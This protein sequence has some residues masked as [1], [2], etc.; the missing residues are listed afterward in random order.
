MI[1]GGSNNAKYGNLVLGFNLSNVLFLGNQ[2]RGHILQTCMFKISLQAIMATLEVIN[3]KVRGVCRQYILQ[4][5]CEYPPGKCGFR[6]PQPITKRDMLEAKREIGRCYCGASQRTIISSRV[7]TL[8]EPR[9]F[10]VVCSK[11][12][13]SMTRCLNK[14]I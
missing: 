12:G 5:K 14:L 10:F 4:G 9:P 11:T 7:R 13:K 6:H 8:E 3:D 2:L 1:H